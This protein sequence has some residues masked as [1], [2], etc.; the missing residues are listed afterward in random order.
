MGRVSRLE[1]GGPAIM[2]M[3]Q[4]YLGLYAQDTWRM[5]SRVTLN[6]GLRWEPY[7]GA[8]VLNGAVYNFSR[9]NFQK[10]IETAVFNNAPAGLI[11]PGDPGFPSG[12]NRPATRSGGTCRRVVGVAWDVNGRRPHGA[13]LGLRDHV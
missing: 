5:T 1:H 12:Q 10:G 13:A 3:N 11:Y 4:W 6:A 7:F 9:D 2:P 8:S